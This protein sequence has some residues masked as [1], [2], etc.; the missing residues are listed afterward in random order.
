[1]IRDLV[2]TVTEKQLDALATIMD[3]NILEKVHSELA[4]CTPSEFLE[5]YLELDPAFGEIQDF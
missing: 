4:P 3:E 5:R 2:K 1:M